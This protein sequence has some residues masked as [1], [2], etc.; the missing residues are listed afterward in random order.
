MLEQGKDKYAILIFAF[1][2]EQVHFDDG[3]TARRDTTKLVGK[4]IRSK[5]ASEKLTEEGLNKLSARA[6]IQVMVSVHDKVTCSRTFMMLKIQ[7]FV[8]RIE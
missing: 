6:A 8:F 5:S 3:I 1:H 7:S 2:F 4:G